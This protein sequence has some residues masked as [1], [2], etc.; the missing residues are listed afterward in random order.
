[1][2]EMRKRFL[3]CE[4]SLTSLGLMASGQSLVI[5]RTYVFDLRSLTQLSGE[6]LELCHS[7]ATDNP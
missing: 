3:F 4:Q 1:M 7:K 2:K 5:V 6:D